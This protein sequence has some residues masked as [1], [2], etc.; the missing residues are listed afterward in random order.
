MA[1]GD[2]FTGRLTWRRLLVLLRGL[3]AGSRLAS[4]RD[5]RAAW[6][7]SEQ[8]AAHAADNTALVADELALLRWMYGTV[9]G[10]KGKRPNRPE[11]YPRLP[12]PG[13]TPGEPARPAPRRRP[14]PGQASRALLARTAVPDGA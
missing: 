1:L 6:T 3:P 12:R 14:T 2:L 9:H 8:L 5:P 13:T 4:A 10:R 11:P 7:R